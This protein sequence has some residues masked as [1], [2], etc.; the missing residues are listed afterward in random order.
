MS[1][2]LDVVDVARDS[3]WLWKTRETEGRRQGI[4]DG[5][6]KP[7][8]DAPRVLAPVSRTHVII[9]VTQSRQPRTR[10][11]RIRQR[12]TTREQSR[13]RLDKAAS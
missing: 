11:R 12:Q 5:R 6:W 8:R 3:V 1:V 13:N 4:Y 7:N 2:V 9:T 10:S